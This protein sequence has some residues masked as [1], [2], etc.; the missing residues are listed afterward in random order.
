MKEIAENL[1]MEEKS[2]RLVLDE[3]QRMKH[4]MDNGI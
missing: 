1:D 3:V 4:D 2:R